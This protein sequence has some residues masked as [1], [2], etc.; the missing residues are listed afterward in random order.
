MTHTT[1]ISVVLPTH[2]RPDRLERALAALRAQTLPG[3]TYEV[4]VIDDGSGPETVELLA[5]HSARD[6]QPRLI[7]LRQEPAAGPAAARNRGWRAASASLIAF[8]DDDCEP[9]PGWLQALLDAAER[10]P[11]AVVQ[12]PTRP[13]PEELPA[14]GPFSHTVNNDAPSRGFE[15]ANILYPRAVL[16]RLG[17]FDEDSFAINFGEDTD[18]GWRAV[19]TG[20]P[21]AWAP[22]AL[23]H[24][25]VTNLGP[26]RKLR[27]ARRAEAAMVS[28]ARHDELRRTL[29]LRVFWNRHHAEF[30]RAVIALALPRRLR[31]ARWLLA[32]PY[33]AF[34]VQRRSG[35]LLAPYLIAYDVIEVASCVRGSLRHRMLVI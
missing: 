10:H 22:D 26:I 9:S 17:G 20:A 8:T 7:V 14:Y 19:E 21:T 29:H 15:T 35:P 25:A 24:H 31:W 34:L 33:V 6:E 16:E 5:E 32:A 27:H 13:I 23:V 1:R 12:G 28:F 11:R 30:G 3:D 18:L 4:I 2:D